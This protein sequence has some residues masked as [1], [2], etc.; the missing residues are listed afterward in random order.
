M[1]SKDAPFTNTLGMKFVPVPIGG[2]PTAG[3]TVLFS[4]WDTRIRDYSAYAASHPRSD[5]G[6]KSMQKD[7]IP[8][9]QSDHPTN[10][11]VNV[12][13]DDAQ[14][15]CQWLTTKEQAEGKLPK[16]VRYRLPN[17]EE[18]S[19]AAGLPAEAG[20]TLAEKRSKNSGD[21]LWGKAWPPP[22]NVANY[23]DE[24]YHS[25]FPEKKRADGVILNHWIEGYTDGYVT[26]SPVGAFPANAYGLYDISGN[27][28]QWCEDW[29][30]AAQKERVVRGGCW[31]DYNRDYLRLS[32]RF[33]GLPDRSTYGIGFRCVL[34]AEP[35][36]A[37]SQHP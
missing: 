15:F 2:G 8:V 16:G 28:W 24:S 3:Q 23:G 31:A 37:G 19:W 27:V 30:D 1:A 14:A 9:G 13:W 12:S 32:A 20:D 18:W 35:A 7:G 11:P 25:K 26:T 33:H 5:I 29:S 36:A 17:D 34:S 4:I 22:P 10:H 6:W 21:Y